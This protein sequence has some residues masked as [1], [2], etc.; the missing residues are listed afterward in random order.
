LTRLRAG[1]RREMR[2][3]LHDGEGLGGLF[4]SIS[5]SGFLYHQSGSTVAHWEYALIRGNALVSDIVS[6]SFRYSLGD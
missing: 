3:W 2:K 4:L 5:Q 6:E 1:R